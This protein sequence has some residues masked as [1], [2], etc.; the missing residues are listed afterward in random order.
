MYLFFS[1]SPEKWQ[2]PMI[3]LCPIWP[4]ELSENSCRCLSGVCQ[5]S[6]CQG[7]VR[8]LSG[9]CQGCVR[10]LSVRGLSAR[11]LSG[12]CQVSVRSLSGVC[13][14]GVCQGSVCQVSVRGLSGRNYWVSLVSFLESKN[15]FPG[16]PTCITE[17]KKSFSLPPE[18]CLEALSGI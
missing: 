6:I 11:G 7:S 3:L 12:V 10:G 4:E 16:S 8:C 18:S 9:V 13:L 1:I 5:G 15:D 14:S 17:I 2:D